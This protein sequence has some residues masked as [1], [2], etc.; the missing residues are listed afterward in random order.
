[1]DD[2]ICLGI[3][4]Y[5]ELVAAKIKAETQLEME[6][7]RGW[8][9]RTEAERLEENT[10]TLGNMLQDYKAFVRGCGLADEFEAFR[11]DN[12]FRQ[13]GDNK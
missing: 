11:K 2:K 4:Q 12:L 6:Q 1:M 9:L 8:E 7:M 13:C 5:T 3:E 10:I